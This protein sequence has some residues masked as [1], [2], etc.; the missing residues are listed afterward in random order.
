MYHS[1]LSLRAQRVSWSELQPCPEGGS[2]SPNQSGL[3]VK[4]GKKF[5][6]IVNLIV[7]T[8]NS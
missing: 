1:G 6:I 4:D 2:A 5:E 8:M 3:I 7:K